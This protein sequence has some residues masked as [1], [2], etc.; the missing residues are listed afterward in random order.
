MRQRAFPAPMT[1]WKPAT[2]RTGIGLSYTRTDPLGWSL[3]T[4]VGRVWRDRTD[5]DFTSGSGLD[6]ATSDWLLWVNLGIG[7]GISLINR[8]LIDDG[9]SATSN[10]ATIDWT[11][12]AP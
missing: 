12:S 7:D 8:A 10:E 9:F 3:G 6:G 11:G 1:R 2:S 4:T 5:A